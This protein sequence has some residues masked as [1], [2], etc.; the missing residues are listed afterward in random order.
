MKPID[1]AIEAVG[2]AAELARRLGISKQAIHLWGLRA[3]PVGRVADVE[4]VTGIPK[5]ELRPDIF[6]AE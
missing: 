5:A 6:G 1:R 4:K 2:S 3:I